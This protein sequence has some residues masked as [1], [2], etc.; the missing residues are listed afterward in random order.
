M[1]LLI[2]VVFVYLAIAFAKFILLLPATYHQA[3]FVWQLFEEKPNFVLVS[4]QLIM[5]YAVVALIWPYYLISEKWQ[6]FC[7]QPFNSEAKAAIVAA[8]DIDLENTNQ[9]GTEDE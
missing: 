7:F 4:I 5:S 2:D 3:S 6:F 1:S 8:L 9:E